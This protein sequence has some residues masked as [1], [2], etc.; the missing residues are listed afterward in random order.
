MTTETTQAPTQTLSRWQQLRQKRWF[1]WVFDLSIFAVLFVGISMFQGRTLVKSG[2]PAPDFALADMHGGAHEL[3]QYQGKKTLLVFWAPWCGV[4]GAESDNIDRVKSWL[5]DRIN[6]ISVVLDYQSDA[7][8]QK[9]VDKHEVTYPVLMGNRMVQRDYRI[10]AYPTLYVLN[11][12][13]E[14]D[15]TVAGYTTTFGMLWRALL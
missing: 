4:C 5:G 9:F 8:V 1:R 6:V 11:E 15:Y 14:I 13:G 12:D 2:Q 7:D 3:K 10:S